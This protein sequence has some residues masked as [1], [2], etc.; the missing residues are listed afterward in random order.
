M[1]SVS[2]IIPLKLF[3]LTTDNNLHANEPHGNDGTSPDF[4]NEVNGGE[5]VGTESNS[6]P[7][8]ED[9]VPSILTQ[10]QCRL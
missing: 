9:S 2:E 6:N 4:N 5:P 1:M 10:N 7:I 8:L 3:K